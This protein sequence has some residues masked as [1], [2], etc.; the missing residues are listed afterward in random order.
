MKWKQTRFILST[1]EAIR[2]NDSDIRGILEATAESGIN[3]VELVFKDRQS[4][5]EILPHFRGTGLKAIVQDRVIGGIGNE[6]AQPDAAAMAETLAHFQPYDDVIEGYYLWDE[7]V[8]EA[9]ALC[10]RNQ[11]LLT[12]Q[13]PEKLP[14]FNVFPSYGVYGWETAAYNWNNKSYTGYIDGFLDT[15]KPV[16]L[17]MDHYPYRPLPSTLHRSDIWRDVGYCSLR[18]RQQRIPFW[19]YFEGVDMSTGDLGKLTPAHVAAQMGG[20]L[21]YNAKALSWFCSMGVLTDVPGN[22]LPEYPVFKEL[23]HRIRRTGDQLFPFQLKAVH[24]SDLTAEEN[25]VYFAEDIAALD[26]VVSLPAGVIASLFT[27]ENGRRALMLASKD[28]ETPVTGEVVLKHPARIRRFDDRTG[29]LSAPLETAAWPVSLA[30][31][32]WALWE[33]AF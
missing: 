19:F 8:S 14:F 16:V 29:S 5:T 17:A 4:V 25:A 2:T 9:F 6:M 15:V 32:D 30:P 13:A 27:D 12:A 24:H 31:G 11:E 7:P 33:L 20:A 22:R 28:T 1:F 3:T 21:A 26:P 10:R 18:A 23:N